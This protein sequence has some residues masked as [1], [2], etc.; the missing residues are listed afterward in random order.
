[1]MSSRR[2]AMTAMGLLMAGCAVSKEREM[3]KSFTIMLD[4][5]AFSVTSPIPPESE[6]VKYEPT[7]S[8]GDDALFSQ[9]DSKV[10]LRVHWD[11]GRGL[12]GNVAGTLGMQVILHNARDGE[13]ASEPGLQRQIQTSL[14]R[15]LAKVKYSGGDSPLVRLNINGRWW[16]RYQVPILGMLEYTTAVSSRRY[17]TVQF[18]LV[19]N[20]GEKTPAWQQSAH[21]LMTQLVPS[22][23]IDQAQ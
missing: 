7:V 15:E 16:F 19:D 21:E 3:P 13:V 14:K 18:A 20:T 12:L 5:Q 23:R 1:M 22:L 2:A 11:Y 9:T 4:R 6:F 17:L 8:L 10:L